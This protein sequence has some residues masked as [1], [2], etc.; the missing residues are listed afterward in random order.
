MRASIDSALILDSDLL[1]S[2]KKLFFPERSKLTYKV[3]SE[4][5]GTFP[6]ALSSFNKNGFRYVLL[7]IH[8]VFIFRRYDGKSSMRVLWLVTSSIMFKIYL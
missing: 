6:S 3:L 4:A 8:S 5:V 2:L 1:T 7:T